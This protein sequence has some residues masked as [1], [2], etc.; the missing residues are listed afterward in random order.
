[1]REDELLHIRKLAGLGSESAGILEK[2]GTERAFVAEAFR[3][4]RGNHAAQITLA[5]IL[6]GT[7]FKYPYKGLL[8]PTEC[9]NKRGGTETCGEEDSLDHLITC[10]RL[11][12]RWGAGVNSIRVMVTMARRAISGT[13]GVNAPRYIV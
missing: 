11:R 5:T 2:L 7:R 10:Y 8:I 3:I 4:L 1:M 13:P 12:K 9:T 6:C